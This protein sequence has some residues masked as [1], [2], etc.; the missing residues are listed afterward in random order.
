MVTITI[1]TISTK[2]IMIK[3]HRAIKIIA[4]TIIDTTIIAMKITKK[5]KM[6]KKKLKKLRI[7]SHL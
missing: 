5:W 6:M 3:I 1:I 2:M 4:I 7:Q